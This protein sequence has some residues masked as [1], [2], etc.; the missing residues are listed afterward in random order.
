MDTAGTEFLS[1]MDSEKQEQQEKHTDTTTANTQAEHIP[2][3]SNLTLPLETPTLESTLASNSKQENKSIQSFH[4]LIQK[5]FHE[6]CLFD[7]SMFGKVVLSS[8]MSSL[9]F[10]GETIHRPQNLALRIGDEV[11]VS[12]DKRVSAQGKTFV[13]FGFFPFDQKHLERT[14]VVLVDRTAPRLPDELFNVFRAAPVSVVGI[15]PGNRGIDANG[16]D[17]EAVEPLF[18]QLLEKL[19]LSGT[20]NP[21]ALLDF[22]K[23]ATSAP[24]IKVE[25]PKRKNAGCFVKEAP[26][27]KQPNLPAPV[28]K[29]P[30]RTLLPKTPDTSEPHYLTNNQSTPSHIKRIE[31]KLDLI[32]ESQDEKKKGEPEYSKKTWSD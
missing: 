22:I 19:S 3:I 28:L 1:D 15:L 24:K 32:M 8:S 30:P 12:S 20:K 9:Q 4:L 26:A 29:R 5:E 13:I 6:F 18:R 16:S 25:R 27:S 11:F 14:W 31:K 10:Q 7:V 2:G 21:L 17:V 23:T